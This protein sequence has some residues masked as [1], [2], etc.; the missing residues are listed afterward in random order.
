VFRDGTIRRDEPIANR[1]KAA[2]VLKMLPVL[3]E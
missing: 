3:E 1:A 2:E